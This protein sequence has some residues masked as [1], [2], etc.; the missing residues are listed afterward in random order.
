MEKTLKNDATETRSDLHQVTFSDVNTTYDGKPH[1]IRQ[2]GLPTEE[3]HRCGGKCNCKG[4]CKDG[5]PCC[6]GKHPHE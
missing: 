3:G 4:G 2:T 1:E 6:G 5:G